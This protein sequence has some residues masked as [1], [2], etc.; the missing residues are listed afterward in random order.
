MKNWEE[1]YDARYTKKDE[2]QQEIINQISNRIII[3][4]KR[5][6]IAKF[7]GKEVGKLMGVLNSEGFVYIS[8]ILVIPDHRRNAVASSMIFI[9]LDQ[10]AI[11]ENAK[12]IWL[13]VEV[14]NRGAHK[15]YE[16]LGMRI[17]Y[18]YYYLK[19]Q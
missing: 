12:Y 19:S 4:K 6:I 3:P 16:A 8:D 2:E 1:K 9:L 11:K 10:W 13:Q 14:E 17:A 5:F 15:L 7:K 18:N